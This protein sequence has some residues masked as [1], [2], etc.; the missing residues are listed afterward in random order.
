MRRIVWLVSCGKSKLDE[1][2][3]ARDLYT[4]DLFRKSLGLALAMQPTTVFVLSAL[5]GVVDLD[6]IVAPYDATLPERYTVSVAMWAGAV[7]RQLGLRGYDLYRDRFIGLA[8]RRYLDPLREDAAGMGIRDL[9][10]PMRGMMIGER[11]A[12]LKRM[13]IES[14]GRQLGLFAH[15]A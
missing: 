3:P 11:K 12:W 9:L 14:E 2:A 13:L 8:P 1:P 6:E 7:I 10:D 4:G 5:H 15:Q